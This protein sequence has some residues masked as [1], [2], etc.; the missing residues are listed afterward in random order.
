MTIQSSQKV[1]AKKHVP[2]ASKAKIEKKKKSKKAALPY[3][4]II[5]K[6]KFIAA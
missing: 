6:K 2:A 5:H 1:K 3:N 4:L